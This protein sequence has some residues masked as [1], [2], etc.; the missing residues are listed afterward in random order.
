MDIEPVDDRFFCDAHLFRL[1]D[2]TISSVSVSAVRTTRTHEMAQGN[3]DLALVINLQGVAMFSQLGREATVASGS[4]VLI[5]DAE[6]SRMER[7]R[8]R[9]LS[10][11]APRAVLAPM[12]SD[13]DATLLSVQARAPDALRLLI[14]YVDLLTRDP[15]LVATAELRRLAVHHVQ[16]LIALTVGATRDQAEIAAGRGLRVARTRAIKFDIARNLAGGDI[17]AD[18]LSRRHRVSPRYI[19][20]L[21]EAENTSLSQFV[22]GQRLARVRRMLTDPRHAHRTIGELA[23][24]AG[25]GDLSTF[26]REFRRHF[27]TTPTD[28]R[29]GKH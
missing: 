7:T 3:D 19:R 12:L 13:P 23:F 8:S 9:S 26:N 20:K 22:L 16:D 28:V 27:A 15:T 6:P 4:A 2:L 14:G 21:F 25:F 11:H 5:S 10:I 1:P 17:S 29:R 18:A 24:A